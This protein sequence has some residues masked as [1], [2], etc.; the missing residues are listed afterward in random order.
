MT[1]SA[2]L[3]RPPVPVHAFIVASWKEQRNPTLIATIIGFAI[4]AGTS[5]CA[6]SPEIACEAKLRL[7]LAKVFA[8]MTDETEHIRRRAQTEINQ[9]RLQRETLELEHGRVWN[10]AELATEFEVLGFMAPIVAVKRR[11]IRDHSSV[12]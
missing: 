3:L 10:S 5:G 12:A 2:L 8:C 4:L 7:G 1:A 11:S 6:E 9:K